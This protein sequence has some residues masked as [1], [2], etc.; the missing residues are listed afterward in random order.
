MAT[1]PKKK[2]YTIVWIDGTYMSYPLTKAEFT[3]ICNCVS[4]E[5]KFFVADCG[6]INIQGVRHIVEY[7]PPTT[8]EKEKAK[9]ANPPMAPE[10]SIEYQQWREL[11]ERMGDDEEV[12]YGEFN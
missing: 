7:K 9:G 2:L 1:K 11:I 5:E 6:V 4:A 10:E 3:D 8:K 12:D